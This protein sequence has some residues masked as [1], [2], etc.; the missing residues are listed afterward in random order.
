MFVW[1][2]G[3]NDVRF[4]FFIDTSVNTETRIRTKMKADIFFPDGQRFKKNLDIMTEE[5]TRR[6]YF[7]YAGEVIY[8]DN[9]IALSAEEFVKKFYEGNLV[10]ADVYATLEK[11]STELAFEIDGKLYRVVEERHLKCD[12]AH[13]VYFTDGESRR[14]MYTDE[15]VLALTYQ[16]IVPQIY[17]E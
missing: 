9:F 12:L 7:R 11:Y 16:D 5:N 6:K 2:A 8:F 10:A 13:T 3:N 4:R 15:L 14:M 17:I 1:Y